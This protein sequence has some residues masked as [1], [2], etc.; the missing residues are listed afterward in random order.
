MSHSMNRLMVIFALVAL[1]IALAAPRASAQQ[2]NIDAA[3]QEGKVIVYGAQVPQAMKS[4][5]AA[6]EKKYGI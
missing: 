4:L 3:K 6:F 1:G 2:P 5:H